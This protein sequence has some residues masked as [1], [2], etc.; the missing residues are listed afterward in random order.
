M[1]SFVLVT[2]MYISKRKTSF[3]M[4]DNINVGL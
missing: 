4:F 3:L 2:L 1:Q